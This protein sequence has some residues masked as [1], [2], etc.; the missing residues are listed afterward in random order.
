MVTAQ[1]AN[2]LHEKIKAEMLRRNGHGSL[3]SFGGSDYNFTKAPTVGE[4]VEVEHGDKTVDLIL[5]IEDFGDLIL[6]E[7]YSQIPT[8][9]S[10]VLSTEI[11]RLASEAKTG[12]T[13]EVSSCRG[14]CTGLCVGSCHGK[15]NGCTGCTASCGTGCASGCNTTCTGGCQ[16]NCTGSCNTGCST[17]CNTT[18]TGST[19]SVGK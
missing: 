6:S 9:F 13:S 14:D 1:Q 7:Q 8:D 10:E 19:K 16:G 5:Q 12:L 4:L 18:C 3:A 2:E 17:G 15:C 11:D